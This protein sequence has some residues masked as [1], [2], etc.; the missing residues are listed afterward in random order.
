MSIRT[1]VNGP[2]KIAI[3]IGLLTTAI[4]PAVC[5][6]LCLH[7]LCCPVET[8]SS[9]CPP[10]G[11]VTNDEIGA[12]ECCVETKLFAAPLDISKIWMPSMDGLA[13]PSQTNL[14]HLESADL[15]HRFTPEH[16]RLLRT[17]EPDPHPARGPPCLAL[18][19]TFSS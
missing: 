15:A 2:L 18:D 13:A 1:L 10:V 9:C 12:K 8:Q 3:A 5:A 4:L 17:H 6:T 16:D 14:V 7:S 11:G 19:P